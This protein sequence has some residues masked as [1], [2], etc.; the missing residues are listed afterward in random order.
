MWTMIALACSAV[1]TPQTS[2]S[3]L[4]TPDPPPPDPPV[5]LDTGPTDTGIPCPNAVL[6]SFP[7]L[8]SDDV[9]IDSDIQL[10]LEDPEPEATI[11]V[12]DPD[13]VEIE[14]ETAVADAV[15]TW[16]GER[17]QPQTTYRVVLDWSCAPF[18]DT[19]TTNAT[20]TPTTEAFDGRTY[21]LDLNQGHWVAPAGIGPVLAAA[22]GGTLL[23]SPEVTGSESVLFHLAMADEDGIQERCEETTT[24][25]EATFAD[26]FFELAD[27]DFTFRLVNVE[28]ALTAGTFS[29]AFSPTVD[30]IDGLTLAGTLDTRSLAEFVVPGG[31]E[32]LVC[33]LTEP[34][35]A[36][37]EPC[38]DG[39]VTCLP[40]HV[41]GL[42]LPLLPGVDLEARTQELIDVDPACSP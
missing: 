5:V 15:V 17:L 19:L 24:L 38:A 36:P 12:F 16:S 31:P 2:S 34:L 4:A 20:G 27:A 10:L 28:V 18:E 42:V 6:S 25:P 3:S 14:G 35:G 22:M 37:C 33:Q 11:A 7:E 41:D 21:S 1:E 13:G 40:A 23:V 32:D 30:R 26:P 9:Y 29:G 8:G 39:V